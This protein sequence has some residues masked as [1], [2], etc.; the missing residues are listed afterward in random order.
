[1]SFVNDAGGPPTNFQTVYNL[2]YDQ[3]N[4][5]ISVDSLASAEEAF[6][7]DPNISLEAKQHLRA[8]IST[9]NQA[10]AIGYLTA[11]RDATRLV[12]SSLRYPFHTLRLERVDPQT[13]KKESEIRFQTEYTHYD[14]RG[15]AI[16]EV[17]R[18]TICREPGPIKRY[19]DG[20]S[21]QT[22]HLRDTNY[23][24]SIKMS[25]KEMVFRLVRYLQSGFV[26]ISNADLMARDARDRWC[27]MW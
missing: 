23:S 6:I 25:R 19:R 18:T 15:N 12:L 16:A 11:Y 26:V 7:G 2:L 13:G 10:A 1:M 4:G 9:R 3:V 17:W 27:G 22:T 8:I 5:R 14:K 24:N 21:S 20:T